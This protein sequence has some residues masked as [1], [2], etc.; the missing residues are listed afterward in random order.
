LFLVEKAEEKGG[1]VFLYTSTG[2]CGRHG[3][4]FVPAEQETSH[5]GNRL[6]VG[7]LHGPWHRFVRS[8]W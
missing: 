5:C 6:I 7:R 4:A 2:F 3:V 1:L 8:F